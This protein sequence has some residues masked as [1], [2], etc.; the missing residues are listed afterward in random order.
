M[1]GP[2]RYRIKEGDKLRTS[3]I[4]NTVLTC[5]T[6]ATILYDDGKT[7]QL[8]IPDF[9]VVDTRTLEDFQSTDSARM[10]GWVVDA[11]AGVKAN[12][13]RGQCFAQVVIWD[14]SQFRAVLCRGY[15]YA[16]RNISLGEFTEPGPG[17]GEGFIRTVTGTNPAANAEASDA[18]PSNAI[19]KLLSYSIVLVADA[20]AANRTLRFVIDDGAA[21]NR[22]W[23]TEDTTAITAG[24]TRTRVIQ[25]GYKAA[26]NI[27]GSGLT[28]TDTIASITD[29]L[30]DD[31][32]MVEAY[33]M[34][35]ITPGLQA[36]DNYAAPIFQVEEW[37]VL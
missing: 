18:V 12:G 9:A 11:Y 13:K 35:T 36:T 32:V 5:D 33:R 4:A 30:P 25:R 23:V 29:T 31:L 21:A 7:G 37:L 27:G 26:M 16:L 10:D 6:V 24:Q 8:R 20:N 1:T 22:R 2:A 3:T 28:D 15:I 19:W 14:G 34:R 17:G